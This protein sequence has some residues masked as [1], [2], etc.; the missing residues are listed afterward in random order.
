MTPKPLLDENLR[1]SPLW[2]AIQREKAARSLDIVRA[3]D[4]DGSPGGTNDFE[5]LAWAAEH[6]RIIVSLDQNTLPN[7]FADFLAAGFSSPGLIVL[8]GFLSIQELS[9]IL[10]LVCIANSSEDYQDRLTWLP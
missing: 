7:F 8:H 1:S 4:V 9:E 10:V 6:D 3:G 5:L 2:N